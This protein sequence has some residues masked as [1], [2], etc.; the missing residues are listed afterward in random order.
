M[1]RHGRR[2][3]FESEAL[4]NAVIDNIGL[5]KGMTVADLGSGAGRFTL[6]IASAVGP[7]GKVYAID[8]DEGALRELQGRARSL[9]INNVE[10]IRADLTQGIPLPPSSIDVAFMAN[11]L[12]G[13]V[14]SGSGE[15]VV[16]EVERVLRSG[17]LFIVVDFIKSLTAFGP[18][19]W[20]RVSPEE[21][22]DLVAKASTLLRLEE[23]RDDIGFSHYLLK[24]RKAF[25]PGLQTKGST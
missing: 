10:T 12:H 21:V 4:I 5:S 11:V 7:D 6:G 14:H 20:I 8:V 19:P 24:F 17:G 13:F 3:G 18:P 2:G 1:F 22:V 23:R 25:S 9:G 16:K 15:A